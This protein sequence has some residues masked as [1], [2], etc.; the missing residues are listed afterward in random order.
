MVLV[1]RL[2]SELRKAEWWPDTVRGSAVH[3]GPKIVAVYLDD[4]NSA[5]S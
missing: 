3:G 4:N 5:Q 2:G 1:L